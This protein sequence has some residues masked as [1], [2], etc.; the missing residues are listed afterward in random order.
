M[1]KVSQFLTIQIIAILMIASM[2]DALA[3][4]N[5][6]VKE[7]KAVEKNI[8]APSVAEEVKSAATAEVATSSETA[9]AQPVFNADSNTITITIPKVVKTGTPAEAYASINIIVSALLTLV[10]GFFAKRW[11]WLDAYFSTTQRKVGAVGLASALVVCF[12]FGFSTDALTILWQA[13][14]GVFGMMGAYGFIQE[15]KKSIAA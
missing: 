11:T 7:S 14:I 8:Q 9:T 12:I 15:K 10:L 5:K 2:P 13:V 1:K 3:Q 4:Q 6:K